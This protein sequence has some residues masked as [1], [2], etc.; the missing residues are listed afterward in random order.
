MYKEEIEI[1]KRKLENVKDIEL[2]EL[3]YKLL[4]ERSYLYKI[5]NIDPLTGLY[6]RRILEQIKKCNVVLLCDVDDFKNMVM[7]LGIK[8]YRI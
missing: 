4:E 3:V 7:M 6:N 5:S 8:F 2:K 1:I